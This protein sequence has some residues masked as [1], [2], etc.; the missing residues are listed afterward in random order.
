[1]TLIQ[2]NNVSKSY[3]AHAVLEQVSYQIGER[4]RIG[5]IGPNGCGKTTLFRLITGDLTPEAGQIHRNR[6]I[7][8]GYLAQEPVLEGDRSVL[9]ETLQAF[10]DLLRM[11]DQLARMEA[12]MERTGGEASLLE[13]YGALRDQYERAGGYRFE[14]QAQSVLF[15][16]GFDEALFDR[17]IGLLSG[18]EK[19][20]VAL[21]KLLCQEPEVLLLDEPTNHLDL[22]GVEWL[23]DF[24]QGYKGTVMVVSHD[25]YFLDRMVSKIIEIEDRKA[26]LYHGNYSAYVIAKAQIRERQRAAYDRQQEEIARIEEFI[27]RNIA[28]QKTK[29]AQSRRKMLERLERF[30]RPREHRSV[31]IR[32]DLRRQG[33]HEVMVC[34]GLAKQYNGVPLF[35]DLT[36]TVRRGE[37]IGVVGPNGAGK[38]TFLR[39]LLGQETPDA[40]WVRFGHNIDVG[41]YD[42]ERGDLDPAQTVLDEIWTVDP[43]CTAG[44]MRS[45]LGGFLFSGEEVFKRVGDLSG[46]E[47]SRL[48]LAK[49]ILSK[50]NVLILD[51]PT[52]HLD[53]LSRMVLEEALTGYEGTILTV[54]HDRY[55]LRRIANRILCMGRG[56]TQVYE[57]GYDYFVWK[58]R[59]ERSREERSQEE[60]ERKSQRKQALDRRKAKERACQ[61]LERRATQLENDIM[62]L[63]DEMAQ[64]KGQLEDESVV[65]NWVELDRLH[66]QRTELEARLEELYEA[67]G[68]L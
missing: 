11:R 15:G 68:N 21:A 20:R 7:R 63:E 37:R 45:F 60:A 24:L 33:G 36:L 29:Q 49:L 8:I 35:Q 67:W 12:D 62:A 17:P 46:G 44:E 54:S 59:E 64:I 4:D 14:A 55:F 56:Y 48:A 34:E 52:N 1:M 65:S 10:E 3:G 61:R 53:I 51:E 43:W 39:I 41:Y 47:Q 16:L 22:D 42:Q 66:Q 19:S 18:G 38:T 2:L 40:G 31:R 58:R 32:F 9:D 5:L 27:R 23:E 6:G 25:R 50:V 26:V 28:G 13:R 30:E 57:G